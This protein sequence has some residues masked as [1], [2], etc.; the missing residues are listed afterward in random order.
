M[1]RISSWGACEKVIEILAKSDGKFRGRTSFK[2]GDKLYSERQFTYYAQ[3][4]CALGIV[5]QKHH[6]RGWF[7]WIT[8]RLK[9]SKFDAYTMLTGLPF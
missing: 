2:V 1:I 3:R 7:S 8:Y 4:L 6:S 5:E 9:V